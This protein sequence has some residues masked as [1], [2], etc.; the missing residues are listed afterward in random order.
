M[1]LIW[2]GINAGRQRLY[3]KVSKIW[4]KPKRLNNSYPKEDWVAGYQA[5]EP[6]YSLK[7]VSVGGVINLDLP[8]LQKNLFLDFPHSSPPSLKMS[9][10]SARTLISRLQALPLLSH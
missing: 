4:G 6:F 3:S 9:G 8:S 5:D 7:K 2:E 10:H 1:R